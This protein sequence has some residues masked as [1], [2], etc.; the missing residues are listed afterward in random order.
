MSMNAKAVI[1]VFALTTLFACSRACAGNGENE[2][3][4]VVEAF[5]A[6][7]L[8][9]SGFDKYLM[10]NRHR[11]KSRTMARCLDRIYTRNLSLGIVDT[12]SCSQHSDIKAQQECLKF[13][14]GLK[15][16]EWTKAFAE[17]VSSDKPWLDHPYGAQMANAQATVDNLGGPNTY[18]AAAIMALPMIY[19]VIVDHLTCRQQ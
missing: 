12:K 13:G 1:V 14:Q 19:P 5:S 15:V 9:P 6:F 10:R 2:S 4:L 7:S 17:V 18:S 8:S 16:A 11:F 3:K